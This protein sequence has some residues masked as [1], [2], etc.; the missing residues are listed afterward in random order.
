MSLNRHAVKRDR[1]EPEIVRALL[2]VGAYVEPHDQPVDLCVGWG[3]RWVWIEVKDPAK[4]PSA[5]KL[6]DRQ[7]KFFARCHALGLPAAVAMTPEDALQ[8]IGAIR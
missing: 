3:G 1:N 7:A 5:R 4:P 8:A 2:A 6:T